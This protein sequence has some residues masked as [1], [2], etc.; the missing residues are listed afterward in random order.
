LKASHLEALLKAHRGERHIIVM[1][2]FPDPDAISSGLA[3]Q[4]IAA[5]FEIDYDIACDGVISHHENVALV[6]LLEIRLVRIP[7]HSNIGHY[8]G[9][10]F[11]DNQGITTGLTARLAEAK[12]PVLAVVDHHEP[13]GLLEPEFADIRPAGGATATIYTEYLE[14]PAEAPAAPD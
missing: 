14:N 13:Q 9:S 2:S 12:I 5:A 6:E 3:Q 10:I 4:M 8:E 11:V 1:Q 7:E